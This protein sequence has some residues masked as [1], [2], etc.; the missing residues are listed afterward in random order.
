MSER[1][2]QLNEEHVRI[3]A[4][5]PRLDA[6]ARERAAHAY[7]A[8]VAVADRMAAAEA[9]YDRDADPRGLSEAVAC[10][11][12]LRASTRWLQLPADRRSRYGTSASR[13]L[14]ERYELVADRQ[15]L[16]RAIAVAAEAVAAGEELAVL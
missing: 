3:N 11:E 16:D 12:E 1:A 6:V 9:R 7:Q 4:V 14:R 5:L 8:L 15:L 13:C 10:F 2:L